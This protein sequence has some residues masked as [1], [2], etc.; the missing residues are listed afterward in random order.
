SDVFG[1]HFAGWSSSDHDGDGYQRGSAGANCATQYEGVTQHYDAC[2][3]YN[4]GADGDAPYL[5]DGVGPHVDNALLD[6]LYLA[7]QP[8][9][10][11][12]QYSR[13]RR[14]ARYAFWY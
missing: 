2:F 10:H 9:P 1:E 11:V 7:V 4:L 6:E 14:I 12:G 5:D 8:S 13:V 3:V